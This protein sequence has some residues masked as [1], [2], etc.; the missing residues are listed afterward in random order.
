[1]TFTKDKNESSPRWSRDA[2]YF[3]FASN[4][5]APQS[6]ANQ[7]QLYLM[8]PDG[9]EARKITEAK[10][11]VGAFAFSR[12]GKWLAFSAGKDDDQ[13]VWI[14]PVAE[15]NSAQP[16]QMTKHATPV[17]SWQFS[18][19]SKRIY[20][21]S[22]D[23]SSK[24]NK[25]RVE[26]KFT[27]RIRNEETPLNHLW[28]IELDSKKETRLTSG[29]DYSVSD[30]TISKDSKY[31]GYRGTP[32]DRY[33]RTV[34][35]AAIYADLYLLEV[36]TGKIERLTDNKEIDESALSFSPDSS[37]IAFS[38]SDD[39]TYFRNNRVYIRPIQSGQGGGQWKKLG[40][41]FDGDVSAS[42]WSEDGKTIY[43]NEGWRATNQLFSVSTETGKVTQLT[44]EKAVLFATLDEDTKR[45]IINYSDPA[46][47]TD[48]F[49][50]PLNQI[51]NRATWKQ[52]TDSNP[53]VKNLALGETEEIEWKSSDGKMVGGVL[54]KPVNYER[55][56]RYPLI[57]QIHGGPASAS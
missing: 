36:A 5:E 14:L 39:F 25:E 48:W 4:R 37:T 43:F 12:D 56:K 9:G 3:V 24:E 17:V 19:D 40:G 33:Q 41:D 8:R 16:Q 18:P 35:E 20:F 47:P 7:N 30:V 57:V 15:I 38:A 26:Q 53:Q 42:F 32:K 34:T 28:A 55:G 44:K 46:T 23:S 50:A 54:V 45:L 10:D 1:M 13:Q 51:N 22:P 52:I 29:A 11:G 27:V 21:I 6:N 2:Q 31:L 49:T